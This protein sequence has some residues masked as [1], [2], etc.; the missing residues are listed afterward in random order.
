[1]LDCWLNINLFF[2]YTF[3]FTDESIATTAQSLVEN[4]LIS[5]M[6]DLELENNSSSSTEG[7]PPIVGD[8]EAEKV[9]GDLVSEMVESVCEEVS[10]LTIE[11]VDAETSP[12]LVTTETSPPRVTISPA[13]KSTFCRNLEKFYVISLPDLPFFVF[14]S[15]LMIKQ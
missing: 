10:E 4:A 7:G 6:K 8:G 13:G 12:S 2:I 3:K 1:M 9:A 15:I 11:G 5:A 14:Y